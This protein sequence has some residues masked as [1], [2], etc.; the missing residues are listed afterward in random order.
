MAKR[1]A[2][3]E[4]AMKRETQPKRKRQRLIKCYVPPTLESLME[5]DRLLQIVQ[6]VGPRQSNMD[7][8]ILEWNGRMSELGIYGSC[9][10]QDIAHKLTDI[11][12]ELM[13]QLTSLGTE[14]LKCSM[15]LTARSGK[16]TEMVL[17]KLQHQKQVR[18]NEVRN[19]RPE[20]A[21]G[22]HFNLS[23]AATEEIVDTNAMQKHK[24]EMKGGQ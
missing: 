15:E 2:P 20:T 7:N 1:K 17:D 6:D 18:V 5:F 13:R 24:V 12:L 22:K 16:C 9:S 4:L 8:L 3:L 23:L 11:D 10:P 19:L 14:T 21:K